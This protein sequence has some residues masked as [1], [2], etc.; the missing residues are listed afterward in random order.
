MKRPRI[1]KLFQPH[2]IVVT[3]LIF[4]FIGL[5]NFVRLNLH[6][7]D[8]FNHGLKD[9]ELTDIVSSRFQDAETKEFEEK[10]VLINSGKPDRKEL[11]MILN[12][13]RPYHPKAVGI[14][15]LLE[16]RKDS[17][18]DSILVES[19]KKT[20]NLV[21]ANKLGT[22]DNKDKIF[23]VDNFVDSIFSNISHNGFVNFVS[24]DNFTVRLFSPEG[25]TKNGIEK[26]FATAIVSL[27]DSIAAQKLSGRNNKTE[28]INYITNINS[29]VQFDKSQV[30]DTSLDLSFAFKDKIVLIG[31]LGSDEWNLPV[32]D[33]YFTPLN[34][35]YSGRS[36][37]DMFGMVIHANII[38]MILQE[39]YIFEF[40]KWLT[41]IL[42]V[43]F[44]YFNVI[45]IR[46]T[47]RKFP[48][49]FHGITRALQIFEFILVFLL[50]S[51]LFHYFNIRIA[52]D[53]GILAL[54]LTY[55]FVMIYESMI[56]KRLPF[57]KN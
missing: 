16:G 4:L 27:T 2:S 34:S 14:D 55:D 46:K 28:R 29:Y 24:K 48:E 42:E 26:A 33:R 10:I 18:I 22:Y 36:L 32:R 52:F 13:I 23:K 17:T 53:T 5:L 47:Y 6:F 37:P 56:R 51:V 7:L 44:C 1:K 21:L 31:Y 19:I 38:S 15:I 35:K 11:A 12:R 9:Y 39:K 25:K 3:I 8:P 50:I 20:P 41:R 40:P 30:L 49:P 54:V 57:L 45:L 43:M